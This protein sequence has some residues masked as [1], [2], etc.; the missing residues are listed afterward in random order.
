MHR[1]HCAYEYVCAQC[2]EAYNKPNA[3]GSA[4]SG[5]VCAVQMSSFQWAARDAR[6]CLHRTNSWK[7]ELINLVQGAPSPP[8][9]VLFLLFTVLE[10]NIICLF[11]TTCT[12]VNSLLYIN[13]YFNRH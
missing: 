1:S 5:T 13:E 11:F 4:P 8:P 3:E 10:I 6:T 12:V 7:N 2:Y 9:F